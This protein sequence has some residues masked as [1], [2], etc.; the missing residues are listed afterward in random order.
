MPTECGPQAM[1]GGR[2]ETS[3]ATPASDLWPPEGEE[4]HF[5]TSGSAVHTAGGGHDPECDTQPESPSPTG[6]PGP[7]RFPLTSEGPLH[8]EGRPQRQELGAR[9]GNAHTLIQNS[10]KFFRVKLQ[11]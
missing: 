4:G 10:I 5:C 6:G 2:G 3:A 9:V 8:R 7:S 1:E 11:S